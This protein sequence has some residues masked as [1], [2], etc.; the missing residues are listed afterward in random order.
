M[1]KLVTVIRGIPAVV[2][3]YSYQ[4]AEPGDRETPPDPGGWDLEICDE[5]GRHAPWLENQM[6]EADWD[7]LMA[8]LW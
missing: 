3:V 8:E 4:A 7:R 5:G 1:D 2:K 6:S